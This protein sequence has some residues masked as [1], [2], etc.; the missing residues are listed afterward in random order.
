MV[1]IT[2]FIGVVGMELM[3]RLYDVYTK[4]FTDD[5]LQ[6]VTKY[7]DSCDNVW[8]C[9]PFGYPSKETHK[10]NAIKAGVMAQKFRDNEIS[11]SLQIANTI[12]HGEHVM[13]SDCSGLVYEGSPVKNMVGHDGITTKYVFC[14]RDKFFRDYVNETLSYY[15]ESIKPNVVWVDDDMRVNGHYPIKFG[16][17]CHD[18]IRAFNTMYNANFT[19]ESLVEEILHGSLDWR[20]KYIEFLKSSVYDFVYQ[21]SSNVHKISPTTKMGYQY[22][23]NGAYS[24][25]GFAYVLDAMRDATGLVPL[26]RPG[27]GAY[28][29]HDPNEFLKKGLDI[30]WQNSM[31]PPYVE[32]KC[33]EIDNIPNV[34]YGKSPD[35][36]AFESTYY[37]AVGNT[38]MTYSMLGYIYEPLEFFEKM[39]HL[40]S[41]NR[42]YWDRLADCNKQS[43]QSGLN[44]YMSRNMWAKSL[45]PKDGIEEL[46]R[47]NYRSLSWFLHTAIP[48]SYDTHDDRVILL[49]PETALYI[50]KEEFNTLLTKNVITDGESIEI[51]KNRGFDLPLKAVKFDELAAYCLYEKLEN[52]PSNKSNLKE[53]KSSPFSYGK[54]ETYY[55]CDLSNCTEIVGR[56]ATNSNIVP[57]L[58]DGGYGVSTAIINMPKGGKWAV[59]GYMPWKGVISFARHEQFL[60]IADYISGNALSSR[61]LTPMQ[62]NILPRVDKDGKTVCISITNCTVGES[63]D[64]KLLIRNPKTENFYYMAQR[65]VKKQLSFDKNGNDYIVKVPSISAWTVGTVFCER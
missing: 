58:K 61:I 35:G 55:L 11:V 50:S 49:H 17:F 48:F 34:L 63:G 57:P 39:F 20:K 18:C 29:D 62:A 23:C 6:V 38:D 16:C 59:F 64:F 15:V 33:A 51:L 52:H 46:N 7:K 9:T 12:G 41:Q 10:A 22:Y 36:V 2:F 3:Q 32:R 54:Q 28:V 44:F 56:Y 27:G 21:L 40:F 45:Q 30:S 19:R 5:V 25:N 13:A 26:T 65:G 53:Y 4:D 42:E 1:L 31:L 37:F 8:L 14:W 47:E 24:G 60:N 43:Y